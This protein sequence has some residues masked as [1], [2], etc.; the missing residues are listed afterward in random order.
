MS[1][2]NTTSTNSRFGFYRLVQQVAAIDPV[3]NKSMVKCAAV[4]VESDHNL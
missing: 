4:G 1:T 2:W 3:S